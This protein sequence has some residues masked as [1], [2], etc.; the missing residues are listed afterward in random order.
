VRLKRRLVRRAAV[1]ETRWRR[2][3]C[4]RKRGRR[5]LFDGAAGV[6]TATAG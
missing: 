1:V 4:V 3:A 5:R 6:E 2:L